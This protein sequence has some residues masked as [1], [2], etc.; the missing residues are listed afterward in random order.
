[1][2]RFLIGRVLQTV[3]SMLVVI[4]IVF[5]LTRLS[6]NPVNLLLDVNASERDQ[7]ILMHHLGLDKPLPVQYAI[8]VKNI[9]RG[10]FGNSVLS[11]RPVTEHIWERLPATA[12]LGL[13]AMFLSVLIGVPLGVY[14]AV[15]RGGALDRAA[16]VFAVLGAGQVHLFL[17]ADGEI[18][19]R[20]GTHVNGIAVDQERARLYVAVSTPASTVAVFSLP[21]LAFQGELVAGAEDLGSEPNLALLR[22]PDGARWL[23]VSADAVVHVRDAGTGAAVGEWSPPTG[24][25]TMVAD[26]R[27]QVIYVPDE[28]GGT[29]VRAYDALGAPHLR[30]GTNR[31]GEGVFDE[32]AEGIL[33]Y[34]CSADGASDDGS[35]FLVVSDQRSAQTEFELFDRR[36][37]QHLGAFRLTGVSNTDGIASTQRPLPGWPR[38]LFAAV[39][40]DTATAVIGWDKIFAATGLCA[41]GAAPPG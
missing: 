7:Q 9:L 14:S 34:R 8:Y 30:G 39:D 11:R 3:L 22:R 1:M 13:V 36:T 38:G 27:D 35:G 5:V 10:D 21:E 17:L 4:S 32:D 23:Y 28:N 18:F 2:W 20:Y 41:T 16:R 12:E 31:L 29:G 37:W 25:E 6:G 33:L 40:D 24:L 15:R 19:R 26:D